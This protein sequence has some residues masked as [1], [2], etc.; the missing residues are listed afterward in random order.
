MNRI[1]KNQI[2]IWIAFLWLCGLGCLIVFEADTFAPATRSARAERVVRAARS[3]GST[4]PSAAD[5]IRLGTTYDKLPLSFEANHG[6]TDPRARFVSRGR[7]YALFLTDDG[8]VLALNKAVVRMGI[9]GANTDAEIAGVGELAGN[10]NYFV[11]NDPAHWRTHIPTYSKVSYRSIYPG[12]DLVYYGTQRQLEYDFVVAPHADPSVI[13]LNVA[14]ATSERSLAGRVR[15]NSA[16]ELVVQTAAGEVRFDKP[17]IY[18]QAGDTGQRTLVE[19]GYILCGSNRVGFQIGSYDRSQA[20]VIDPVLTYSSLVGG[21]GDDAIASVSV[22]IDS[23]G[24]AYVA[25]GTVS[26]D[27]P[28]TSGSL[29]TTFGGAPAICDQQSLFCGDAFITKVNAT[30][31]AILYSTYLGGSDSD[32]AFG[33]AVDGSGN[34]YVT[35]YTKSTNFPVVSAF[36]PNFG[37]SPAVCDTGNPCG[38]V[39][40]TKIDPTGSSLVYSSYLGGS[41]NEYAEAIAVDSQGNA[42][43]TGAT[44]SADFPTTPGSFQP[45]FT[46]NYTCIGRSGATRPCT[47]AFVTKVSSSGTQKVYSTY[48]GGFS[49]D[50][51]GFGIAVDAGGHA[52]VGGNTCGTDFPVTAGAFQLQSGGPCDAFFSTFDALGRKLLYSSYLGGNGYDS[53]FSLAIDVAGDAYLTGMT[54]SSN[55][56]VTAGAF[57]PTP[58]GNGDAFVAKFN[59]RLSGAA[60]L[61]YSSYLGGANSD[62]GAA[63]AADL[64]GNAY[65][66]GDTLSSNF[67]TVSAIQA[68]INGPG[69]AFVTEVNPAGTALLFSTYLGGSSLE[70]ADSVAIDQN[71]A[72][73]V[74][75]WTRSA[76]FPTTAKVFQPSFAG[77]NRDVFVVKIDANNAPGVSLVPASLTFSGQKLG[78]ASPSQTVILHNVGSAS[79]SISTIRTQG[80]FSQTN[81]CGSSLAGGGSCAVS[82]T[83]TPNAIGTRSGS[84]GVSDNA[85]GSPQKIMLSGTGT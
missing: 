45:T 48:L 11:G 51:D 84:L 49:G 27:F 34:A 39:F 1:T 38:D 66:T 22:A 40:V 18:Q 19:G 85:G 67:P 10:N 9:V 64:Q 36:Q 80:D 54:F 79:L 42:Y 61:V 56:P 24:N 13:R 25:S 63:I 31:T 14:E 21:S 37:G 82:V 12:V 26:T 73:Y 15:L 20:L 23:A 47:D 55:F 83:F 33:L 81:N 77:G 65:V 60:S 44:A 58:G 7:G 28:V 5:R 32:Y 43:V 57:Q 41:D 3:L 75:G 70:L 50:E 68:A 6:Q 72:A 74:A 69:D 8:A 17:V 29:Q 2:S 59:P 35:G 46:G 76:D 62:I 30:G 4:R 52:F 71:G 16:G 53:P 78:T